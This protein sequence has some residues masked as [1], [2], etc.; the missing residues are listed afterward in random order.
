MLRVNPMIHRVAGHAP[1]EITDVAAW[2][3]SSRRVLVGF[4]AT[5][6]SSLGSPSLQYVEEVIPAIL[7][8]E[9]VAGIVVFTMLA[10]C[11]PSE[12]A[13]GACQ[14]A[15]GKATWLLDLC[16]KGCAI[17]RAFGQAAA[18]GAQRPAAVPV[19]HQ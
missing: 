13:P 18:H 19:M 10:P 11:G 8:G 7:G 6:H 2:I 5:G 16:A 17:T 3:P 4:Y 15:G 9:R 12:R 14:G 1:G